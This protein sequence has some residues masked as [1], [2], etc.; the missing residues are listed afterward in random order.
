MKMVFRAL[1]EK[2]QSAKKSCRVRQFAKKC[3]TKKQQNPRICGVFGF[4]TSVAILSE[5]NR[6][7]IS[8]RRKSY[9]KNI[10]AAC[11]PGF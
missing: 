6:S 5:L 11:R 2:S 8:R 3:F 9:A 1:P 10:F 4:G 7:A